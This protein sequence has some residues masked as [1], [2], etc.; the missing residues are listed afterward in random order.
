[1][2]ITSQIFSFAKQQEFGN[3]GLQPTGVGVGG[4]DVHRR[5][6]A[7]KKAA[8]M[9]TNE[10]H[11]QQAKKVKKCSAK[12][13]GNCSLFSLQDFLYRRRSETFDSL[14]GGGGGSAK[15]LILG[16]NNRQPTTQNNSSKPTN[17]DS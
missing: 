1:M 2:R 7:E 11:R 3:G 10:L 8:V 4:G 12:T 16:G 14:M 17:P 13:V 15:P 9:A 6:I 5:A